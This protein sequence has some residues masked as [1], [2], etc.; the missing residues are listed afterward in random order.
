MTG[1]DGRGDPGSCRPR[2]RPPRPIEPAADDGLG[3]RL[4]AGARVEVV[5]HA[6]D[7]AARGV[8]VN[9]QPAGNG[10]VLQARGEQTQQF[11]LGRGQI[12]VGVADRCGT[13]P[14]GFEERQDGSAQQGSTRYEHGFRAVAGSGRRQ[15]ATVAVDDDQP[16]GEVGA[17]PGLK[18]AFGQCAQGLWPARMLHPL[19]VQDGPYDHTPVEQ[20]PDGGPER[21]TVR[22]RIG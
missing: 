8:H 19:T 2:V 16:R 10:L 5:E 12:A 21:L 17:H 4:E 3:A 22:R 7:A 15:Q 18:A 14:Q 6:A 9:A 1:I 20:V 13:V 11:P